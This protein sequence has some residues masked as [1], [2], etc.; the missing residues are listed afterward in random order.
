LKLR[1]ATRADLSAESSVDPN[2]RSIKPTNTASY[3][4][5]PVAAAGAP[6]GSPVEEARSEHVGKYGKDGRHGRGLPRRMQQRGNCKADDKMDR[7]SGE[8]RKRSVCPALSVCHASGTMPQTGYLRL[9][10]HSR[11]GA[12]AVVLWTVTSSNV[13]T[14]FSDPN[15]YLDILISKISGITM[16]FLIIA[17]I[18]FAVSVFHA[19]VRMYASQRSGDRIRHRYFCFLMR[20]VFEQYDAESVARGKRESPPM[21]TSFRTESATRLA[22]QSSISLC[23][24]FRHRILVHREFDTRRTLL[25]PASRRI[26]RNHRKTNGR[27]HE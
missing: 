8:A 3:T 5:V 7:E 21:W 9:P 4:V 6:A 12:A 14:A 17:L 25:L 18:T 27:L 1:R 26:R 22:R 11:H 20:H 24:S 15:A 13:T 2:A 19:R 23:S 10:R 16:S